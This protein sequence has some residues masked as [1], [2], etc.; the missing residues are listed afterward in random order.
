MTGRVEVAPDR[1]TLVQYDAGVITSLA[2]ELAGVAGIPEGVPVRVE[3][4]EALPLPLTGSTADVVDG[5]VELWF[6]GADFEDPHERGGFHEG[7]ARA[8][9]LVSLLRASD[10]LSGNFDAAPI[11]EKLTD[12]Q[13]QAWEA[14]AEGRAGRLGAP[15]R[16]V[17]RRY[18]F[19]LYLGFTDAADAAFERLWHG[20]SFTWDDL[21]ALAD[22]AA[23]ADPRPQPTRRQPVRRETLK[24]RPA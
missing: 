14:W 13:R 8:E 21:C 23:A 6:S 11:D 4:D 19:R 7:L 3:I 2:E 1:F 9:L 16:K 10:R 17:R 12:G 24:A 15:T 18:H 5:R 20:D 22:H